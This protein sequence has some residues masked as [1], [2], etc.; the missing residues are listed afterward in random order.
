MPIRCRLERSWR[1]L[2]KSVD[3]AIAD[4]VDAPGEMAETELLMMDPEVE[5][6]SS[7]SGGKTVLLPTGGFIR[8][9]KGRSSPSSR[10]SPSPSPAPQSLPK[11]SSKSSSSPPEMLSE[12]LYPAGAGAI[13]GAAL[14][15]SRVFVPSVIVGQFELKDFHMLHPKVKLHIH[16]WYLPQFALNRDRDRCNLELFLLIKIVN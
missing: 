2:E 10:I 4:L 15:A 6:A 16:L 13:F 5:G 12:A 14:T 3:D 9:T 1:G 11:A 7:S 8:P